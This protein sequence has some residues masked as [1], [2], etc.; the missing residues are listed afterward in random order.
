L[1]LIFFGPA[2]MPTL[3]AGMVLFGL[4][5]AGLVA[6]LGGLFAVDICPKR[7]TGAAMGVIGVFSYLGAAIQENISGTLL[8]Q[9]SHMVGD[10]RVY[11]FGPAIW[12]WIGSAV[13][14][15]LLAATLWRAKL[16][17]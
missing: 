8:E 12:F 2:N 6:S 16:R 11:D 17:D 15:M 4:G 5:M 9:H 7:A 14:S 3:V 1:L 13:V 10:D